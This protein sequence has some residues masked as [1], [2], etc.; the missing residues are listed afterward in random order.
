MEAVK[1]AISFM[2]ELSRGSICISSTHLQ[3]KRIFHRETQKGKSI[4][5]RY[6]IR[7]QTA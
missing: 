7:F 4:L 1:G 6:A 2:K 5:E 3:E